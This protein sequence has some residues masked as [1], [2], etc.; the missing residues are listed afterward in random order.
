MGNKDKRKDTIPKVLMVG[1]GRDVMGG[2]TTVVNS[3]Y[4]LGLDKKVR[5]KYISSMR[6]GNKM[7]K[8]AVAVLSYLQFCVSVR[9]YDIVHVHMAAQASF[10]RK[11]LFIKKAKQ[12]GKK[13]IIHQ[14]AADFDEYFKQADE[15]KKKKIKEIFS[16]AEMVIVLSE[17]WA[18]F[19]GNTICDAEKIIV[20]HNGVI[21]PEY[22]KT[23]R[24][25]TNV[26]FL[27]RL[28]E[29]KGTF[30]LLK[31]IPK[32]LESI[33]DATFYLGGDG[34]VEKCIELVRRTR[35]E[36]HIHF[37][38]W[39]RDAE[40]ESYFRKCSVF[41]LPSYHEGMP[42]SVLEAM[43]YGLATISTN[44]GGIPQIIENG[45]D[46]IRVNAGDINE[47]SDSLIN[48]LNSKAERE[49]LGK[50][51]RRKIEQK[52]NAKNNID[53]LCGLYQKVMVKE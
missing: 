21:L 37:L 20:I 8:L 15:T 22:Q 42:M 23:E 51:G 11:A 38:G 10:S 33:P 30:D 50:A 13:I 47:I 6:D 19:F 1:P 40:K 14:H 35:I 31:A 5:L 43:S 28:G 45:V 46:G 36:S 41:I 52:F 29:R 17:E 7:K 3:Y 9:S 48:V 49:R 16:Y 44:T 34:E 25:D 26:L 4:E 18:E 12:A 27:G 32:V 2:I 24:S 53:A 39:V